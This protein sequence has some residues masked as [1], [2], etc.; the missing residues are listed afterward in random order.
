M[1][2]KELQVRNEQLRWELLQAKRFAGT[3]AKQINEH[4]MELAVLKVERDLQSAGIATTTIDTDAG[5]HCPTCGQLSVVSA[6]LEPVMK[7]CPDCAEEVRLAARKCRHC[8]YRFDGV[9]RA[10]PDNGAKATATNS[11][12][13]VA[14]LG[15]ASGA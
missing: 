1:R 12:A 8:D 7:V 11:G 13:P 5:P 10:R 4:R 15:T 14:R 9:E 6:D 3:Q 2:N